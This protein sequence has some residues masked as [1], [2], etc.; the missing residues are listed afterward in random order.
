MTGCSQKQ[1]FRRAWGWTTTVQHSPGA[2]RQVRPQGGRQA[3]PA[4][5]G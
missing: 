1:G 5:S 2:L 4:A 3:G